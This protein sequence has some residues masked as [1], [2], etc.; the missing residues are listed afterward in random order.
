MTNPHDDLFTEEEFDA[1]RTDPLRRRDFLRK[2]GLSV[3]GFAAGAAML[4]AC[5]E[6]S[7]NGDGDN[8]DGTA[9][10]SD[11]TASAA[12]DAVTATQDGPELE[13][14]MGTSWPAGLESLY[15]SATHFSEVVA[16]LTGG[17][18]VINPRPAGEVAPATEVLPTVRDA[19]ME[20]G[21]T[22]SYYYTGISPV[23]QFPTTVP[24]GLNHRQQAAWMYHGGGLEK[25]QE[26]YANEFNV[27]FFPA[28]ATGVQMGGW[29]TQEVNTVDDLNGLKMRIPGLQGQVLSNLGVQQVQ[30]GGGEI[31][32]SIQ[33]GAIDAA[34]FVGPTDDLI[35]GLNELGSDLYYYYPGWWE[36]GP[37][38]EVE[39][40][41]DKW[42]ELPADYQA[43]IETAAKAELTDNMAYYDHMNPG[44]INQIREFADVREF[45]PEL[46]ARFKEE[47][48]T[49][50][51][52]IANDDAAFAEILGPWREY[53]DGLADWF[54]L[55]ERSYIVQQTA[56]L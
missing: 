33:T 14:Q 34:E 10:P 41:L 28:G 26:F 25:L 29:F 13:F 47:T 32:T 16:S 23:L 30:V 1:A 55:A 21:H 20:M 19:G 56:D 46:M 43:A 49:V 39:I 6:S 44:A 53:R 37:F 36:P 12:T 22:A 42:N 3:A 48:D 52:Q 51:D 2:T 18:F 11:S 15:G 31:L 8:G 45:S 17:R 50:L 5:S 35:L 7:E 54:N 40:N 38:L 9:A 4:A 24:F 27:I